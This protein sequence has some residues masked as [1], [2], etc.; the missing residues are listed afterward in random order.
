MILGM[1]LATFTL[2]HTVISLV[3]IAAGLVA[4][5][6]LLTSKPLPGWTALFLGTTILTSVTGFFF[7]FAQLLPSHIVGIISLVLLAAAV[8]ALYGL[9]LAGVW[10]PVYVVTALLALYLNVFVLIVQMFQKIGPLRDLAPNQNEPPFLAAQGCALLF[11]AV[12]IVVALR[13]YHPMPRYA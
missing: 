10:R 2:V 1:S 7:P 12:V 11:F 6:G 4:M 3:A 8:I 13:R 9:Q 5:V